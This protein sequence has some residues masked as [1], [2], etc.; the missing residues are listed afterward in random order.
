MNEHLRLSDEDRERAAARLAEFYAEGRL[1]A[2]EHA[3]RLDAIWTARTGADLAPIFHDLPREPPQP[4]LVRA[5]Q[6]PGWARQAGWRRL[7][8]VPVIVALVALSVITHLPF[9]ILIFALGFGV[10][11][12][13]ARSCA[14]V[15]P[16]GSRSRTP[17][18]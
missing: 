8:V 6:R 14:G 16:N 15:T 18:P 13:R 1:T 10:W 3:E 9:W 4:R 7:P 12:W 2:D 11:G 5:G 17:H